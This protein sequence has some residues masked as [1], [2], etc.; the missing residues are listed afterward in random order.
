MAPSDTCDFCRS[1]AAEVVNKIRDD[2]LMGEHAEVHLGTWKELLENQRCAGCRKVIQYFENVKPRTEQYQPSHELRFGRASD[3]DDFTLRLVSHLFHA[4]YEPQIGADGDLKLHRPD[5]NIETRTLSL[6]PTVV[7]GEE[8]PA[9]LHIDRAEIDIARLKAWSDYCTQCHQGTCHERPH[10]QIIPNASS[11]ILIDVQDHCLV[12]IPGELRSDY[13]TLSYVWGNSYDS[14]QLTSGNIKQLYERDSLRARKGLLNIPKTIADAI[15]L[16]SSMGIRYLWVDRLCIIQD[17]PTHLMSQLQQMAQIYANSYFTII[18]ADGVD[19][20]HGLRGID[21]QS[22]PRSL[23]HE[24]YEF[25]PNVTMVEKPKWER[26]SQRPRWYTR[27]WTFQERAVSRRTLVFSQ[28]SIYWQCRGATWYETLAAEPEGFKERI[29]Y[30][31]IGWPAYSL[32]LDPWPAIEKY[33]DLVQGYN[34]RALTFESDALNAFKAVTSALTKSF[35]GGFHFGLPV[36]AFDIGMLWSED[37]P[38]RRRPKFPSWSWLGWN[39]PLGLIPCYACAWNPCFT[40]YEDWGVTI[41]PLVTWS[42][43]N[44]DNTVTHAID[45]SYHTYESAPGSLNNRTTEGWIKAWNK[46][47]NAEAFQHHSLPH[48]QFKFPFPMFPPQVDE[49][50][51]DNHPFLK[52]T[53]NSCFLFLEYHSY[54]LFGEQN[55]RIDLRDSERRWAGII[56][57][58]YHSDDQPSRDTSCELIAISKGSAKRDYK[59][60][61]LYSAI[62]PLHEMQKAAEINKLDP[63]TFIN[64]LWI[65][66][67]GNIAYRK[68]M[69]RVWEDAW[70]R[71][72]LKN[73]EVILG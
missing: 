55:L 16:T 41:V 44:A 17:D 73:I 64:V 31:T 48:H 32:V 10:W 65:E 53:T 27:A 66:R 50:Q 5:L 37:G 40:R 38:L 33:F 69:G 71:Q 35:P 8:R 9:Y 21:S 59:P 11:L 42:V 3:V 20:R 34:R 62:Q 30:R 58:P 18:A 2:A 23:V 24:Y 67:V 1:I 25:T 13:T 7:A 15:K 54:E 46:E 29:N 63:Y 70:Y 39:G 72:D 14:I 51:F 52:F 45:N 56:Q 26:S 68:A 57:W 47:Y 49:A 6:I 19:A 61:K 22:S 28:A 36:F 43:I 4:L 60:L 12:Q